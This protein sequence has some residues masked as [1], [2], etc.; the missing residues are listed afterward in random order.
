VKLTDEVYLVGGGDFG[1]G[2]SGD[3]DCHIYA[4]ASDDEVALVDCGMGEAE[5]VEEIIGN[6]RSDGLDPSRVRKLLLT[7][8]HADHAGGAG[9]IAKRLGLAIY[10]SRAAAAALR[11]AD[12]D[13]IGLNIA[14]AA[15]FYPGAYHL[16]PCPIE[17]ELAEGDRVR[18]G[19]LTVSVVD[20]P[21]HCNGHLSFLMQGKQK[22]YLFGGDLVFFGGQIVLQNIPDC[23]IQDYARSVFKLE[24]QRI[25]VF[26]PGHAGISLRNGQ[27]HVDAAAAAF[28][29]LA[30]PRNLF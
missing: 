6:L 18:V 15:G 12:E 17:G 29:S 23:N 22:R 27:R 11:A 25:D 26:L 2:L 4:I 10:A 30:V 20:T 19:D 13:V 16:K 7:H 21:G 5:A 14:K 1:F 8:Y 3:L 9:V 28:R 24:G